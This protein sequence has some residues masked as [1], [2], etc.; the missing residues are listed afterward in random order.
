MVG[1]PR[2]A[3]LDA[4]IRTAADDLLCTAG[5]TRLTM[6]RV[7][8]QASVP[9][10]TLYARWPNKGELVAA[11][12]ARSI[13]PVLAATAPDQALRAAFT[14]CL[15]HARGPYGAACALIVLEASD[16]QVAPPASLTAALDAH[17]D[18]LRT[19]IAD[20]GLDTPGRLDELDRIL[21]ELRAAPLSERFGATIDV[22]H[23]VCRVLQ[24]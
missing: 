17:R 12:V 20:A 21:A 2:D 5:Y 16:T 6:E 1:R 15:E 3:R 18:E 22:D 4:S 23:C 11:I 10:S 14:E 24:S 8:E 7:A 9:R 13:V 19:L